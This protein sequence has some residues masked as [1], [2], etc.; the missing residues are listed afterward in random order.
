MLGATREPPSLSGDSQLP[1]V[2]VLQPVLWTMLLRLGLALL[3]DNAR[4]SHVRRV[5]FAK[6]QQA[7]PSKFHFAVPGRLTA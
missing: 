7:T 3:A 6:L 2:G 1:Q 5:L 4:L